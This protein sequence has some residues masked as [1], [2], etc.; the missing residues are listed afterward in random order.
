M[1]ITR[2]LLQTANGVMATRSDIEVASVPG[3]GKWHICKQTS[4]LSH[5]ISTHGNK[6]KLSLG[7]MNYLYINVKDV[8]PQLMHSDHSG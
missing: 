5:Q 8:H 1:L 2:E 4:L 7:L 3:D 6:S